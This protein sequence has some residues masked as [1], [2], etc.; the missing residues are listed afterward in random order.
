MPSKKNTAK[1][2]Y[3][4]ADN[5]HKSYRNRSQVIVSGRGSLSLNMQ[6]PEVLQGLFNSLNPKRE[7][8]IIRLQEEI[9]KLRNQQAHSDEKKVAYSITEYPV[10]Y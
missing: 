1:M 3:E 10:T 7:A 9:K 8:E 6:N 2:S 5:Y 4:N